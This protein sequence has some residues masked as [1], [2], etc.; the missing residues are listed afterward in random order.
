MLDPKDWSGTSIGT[1]PIGQGIAVTAMQM[2]EAY[3]V[4]ANGGVYVAPRLVAATIDGAGA[5][6][7]APPAAQRRVV[8]AETAAKVNGM[9]QNVVASQDGTGFRA[10]VPGYTVAGKTGTARKPNDNGIPDTRPGAVRLVV[11]RLRA[12]RE[13][14]GVDHRGHRRADDVD[15]RQ[16]RVR[17]GVR[18]AREPRG[19]PAAR[20]L[21]LRRSRR[22]R[23]AQT[24]DVARGHGADAGRSGRRRWRA[25]ADA[26]HVRRPRRRRPARPLRRPPR[27]AMQLARLLDESPDLALS[28]AG[29]ATSRVSRSPRVAYDSRV[30]RLRARCSAACAG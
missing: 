13:P 15:L 9:L 20:W 2:L 16:R 18:R 22:T 30:G 14:A 5:R 24:P 27:S 4:I 29:S 23:P 1:I 21:P 28:V 12:G 7:D 6:H 17:A 26:T 19:A 11:R 3:N 25:P 10:A 8:S